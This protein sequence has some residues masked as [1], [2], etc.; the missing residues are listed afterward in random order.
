MAFSLFHRMI[1]SA[2]LA[3]LCAG[4]AVAM[5]LRAIVIDDSGKPVKD[6]VLYAM[7]LGTEAPPPRKPLDAVMDQRD[8]EFVPYVLPVQT[9]A[10]VYFPNHDALRH[11]VYSISAAKK[12]QL[13]L[14]KSMPPAPVQFDQPGVVV[15]GCNI[16]D[17][18]IAY[19]YVMETPYFSK[20]GK[21]GKAEIR[22]LPRATYDVR[23]W[24]PLMKGAAESLEKRVT[25]APQ[26]GAGNV[27]ELSFR[28]TLKPEWR[29]P[30]AP[31]STGGDYR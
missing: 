12:F 8:K 2:S 7:I 13:P 28:I 21:D 5:N 11:Q 22:D 18:M 26:D 16:H 10:V 27:P 15:L 23:V 20:T 4:N 9:G 25:A 30:R 14:Y 6:A 24:H 17:R 31:A 29:P 3:V 1:L 19:I